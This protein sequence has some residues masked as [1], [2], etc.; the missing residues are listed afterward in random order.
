MLFGIDYHKIIPTI[1]QPFSLFTILYVKQQPKTIFALE[2]NNIIKKSIDGD[3]QAIKQLYDAYANEM[4]SSSLRITNDKQASEDIIQESFLKSIDKLPALEKRENYQ[5]WYRRIVI[6]K[7]LAYIKKRITFENL[8]D[9]NMVE[10]E[11]DQNWYNEIPM[12]S[13]K[14]AIQELPSRSRTIFSLFAI[15]DYKH[16]EIAE[17]LGI[18]K[19]TSKTQYRYAKKLLRAY[20]IKTYVQ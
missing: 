14:T 6:N 20:L 15:E 19:S 13:I 9:D 10:D 11:G 2:I 18:T 16:S 17:E 5:G 3:P 7:S 4:Y 1:L 12:S 8:K